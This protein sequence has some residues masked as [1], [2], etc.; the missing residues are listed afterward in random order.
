M[1]DSL[2]NNS[3][4]DKGSCIQNHLQNI[5]A[6]NIPVGVVILK[7]NYGDEFIVEEANNSFYLTVNSLGKN[8]IK[9][10]KQNYR[11]VII[12]EDWAKIKK[13]IQTVLEKNYNMFSCEY[14]VLLGGSHIFW[15]KLNAT[16]ISEDKDGVS[17]LCVLTDITDIKE[18]EHLLEERKKS[19]SAIA[20][21]ANTGL[22]EYDIVNDIMYD[23]TGGITNRKSENY[24]ENIF[25]YSKYYG[26]DGCKALINLFRSGEEK[27]YYEI[28]NKDPS[29]NKWYGV[30]GKTIYDSD[31]KPVRVIG[32]VLD[33]DSLK[34][35]ELFFEEQVC[36]DSLTGILT[37]DYAKKIINEK[38][39]NETDK[40]HAII[41]FDIDDFTQLN[42]ELG[43]N[44]CDQI[45]L[46]L[47]EKIQEIFDKDD[48][49]GR[50]DGDTFIIYVN[51]VKSK[52]QTI[53]LIEKMQN[54]FETTNFGK[55]S[56][57]K[58]TGSIGVSIIEKNDNNFERAFEQADYSLYVAKSIGKNQ[59]YIFSEK[60]IDP[61][62]AKVRK[63]SSY[64]EK[65][66]YKKEV[67][68]ERE[69]NYAISE[70]A[71]DVMESTKDVDS[72]INILLDR[73]GSYFHLNRIVI[74]EPEKH[75]L[76]FSISYQWCADEL[77]PISEPISFD[78]AEMKEFIDFYHKK[79]IFIYSQY[80]GF[81]RGMQYENH[82]ENDTKSNIQFISKNNENI[83]GYINFSDNKPRIWGQD[84]IKSLRI[85]SKIISSYLLKMRTFKDV[86]ATVD[87][88]IKYETVT[89][90]LKFDKFKEKVSRILSE[91]PNKKYAFVYSDINN[92]KYLN[93]RYTYREGDEILKNFVAK[94][95]REK[96]SLMITARVFS[97]N[98]IS[99]IELDDNVNETN[100]AGYVDKYDK[101]FNDNIEDSYP[102][103]K[104]RIT[105]GIFILKERE[106]SKVNKAF[107]N[108]CI[109]NANTARRY[110]KSI[111]SDRAILF[112]ETMEN[113]VKKQTE[114]LTSM[115]K[116][117]TNNEFVIVLQ[118]KVALSGKNEIV[119]AEA[120]V[121]WIKEDGK[122]VP[123]MDFIPIFEKNGF[124]VDVDFCVYE[125]VC[126]FLSQRIKEGKK[127]VPVSVNVSRVHLE[128]DDFI[129]KIENLVTRYKIPRELLEFELTENV[130]LKNSDKAIKVM[131]MLKN[132][133]FKVSM[134]DFGSG[135]SSLNLLK[136]LPVDVLKMDKG[137]LD[138]E[139]IITPNSQVVIKSVI[140]MAKKMKITVLCEGVETLEQ[141]NFLTCAGCDLAQG[142][143]FSKPVKVDEFKELI[144][145]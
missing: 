51:D 41:V 132:M 117:L 120:L 87:K 34:R 2:L 50:T 95:G 144:S 130:F 108:R 115:E 104:S 88:L 27:F 61:F 62:M 118:P 134:D 16:K 67:G 30:W 86:E 111:C 5:S 133:H 4:P 19:F 119:G 113:Q 42:S 103:I 48:V 45:I 58:V 69:F 70:F 91:N 64:N 7:Y 142:Y 29:N 79:N 141:A 72:A 129:S 44:V 76:N 84:E 53:E 25:K 37:A 80:P 127:V 73:V 46:T 89:G 9:R 123:P 128:K 32:K 135:Y 140:D 38:A 94:M 97:D 35:K 121:R 99:L 98:F 65:F 74:R 36:Y 81:E 21:F 71:F 138:S 26:E 83:G 101:W 126:Q 15:R 131:N 8:F 107:I 55:V 59:Y 109:D 125:Q 56:N 102:E 57:K 23:I 20:S 124:V 93:E 63:S 92:F 105:T 47:S 54:S 33:I 1:N 49:I 137:F 68:A 10:K 12:D 31:T 75:Y 78:K 122:V 96:Y 3:D 22:Y 39:I 13:E 77:V 28:L 40:Q 6:D 52:E 18:T 24:S 139:D 143:Y 116:A 145:K 14:R 66:I 136:N 85:I 17:F 11:D 110:A 100:L 114:I 112:D 106:I 90:A 43:K 82:I 60:D